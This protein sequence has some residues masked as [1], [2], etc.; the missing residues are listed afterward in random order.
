MGKQSPGSKFAAHVAG[1]LIRAAGNTLERRRELKKQEELLKLKEKELDLEERRLQLSEREAGIRQQ[2]K[3]LRGVDTEGAF[4]KW[5]TLKGQ[6]QEA[7]VH[8]LT[9]MREMPGDT[10]TVKGL[11]AQYRPADYGVPQG[12]GL[13]EA[14]KNMGVKPESLDPMEKRK[15]EL[16]LRSKEL[17]VQKAERDAAT[18]YMTAEEKQRAGKDAAWFPPDPNQSVIY[19]PLLAATQEVWNDASNP[20]HADFGSKLYQAVAAKLKEMEG[21][22]PPEAVSKAAQYVLNNLQAFGS[23]SITPEKQGKIFGL[24][25]APAETTYAAPARQKTDE[26]IVAELLGGR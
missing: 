14:M 24:G 20:M 25:G 22:V 18:G 23:Y 16:D 17:S 6:A 26:E 8:R 2:E 21:T 10:P 3:F 13:A 5:D 4:K 19:E 7:G 1:G 15:Q 9:G 11:K 12:P